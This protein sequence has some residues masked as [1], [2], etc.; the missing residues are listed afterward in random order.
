VKANTSKKHDDIRVAEVRK[1]ASEGL[2]SFVVEKGGIVSRDTGGSL[3]VTE[4]MLYAE[5]G[6]FLPKDTYLVF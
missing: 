5:G 1:A 3:V 2:L 4:I 6:K